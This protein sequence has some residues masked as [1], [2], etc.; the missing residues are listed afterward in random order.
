MKRLFAVIALVLLPAYLHAVDTKSEVDRLFRQASSGEIRFQKLVQ[1]SKDSL[2]A[3]GDSA[4]KYLAAK[5]DVTDAREKL[6]LVDIFRGI[7]KKSTPYLVAA[8][9]TDN[10]DQLR[11]TSRCLAD[12]KD[13]A[14]IVSLMSITTH[15]DFT[16]RGEA[17]TAIG[18]SGGGENTASL[19]APM[20]SDSVDL[21]RKCVVYGL[22]AVK[23]TASLPLLIGALD[24]ESFAVRL[25]AYDAIASLDSLAHPQLI[26]AVGA[27]APERQKTL[28]IRLCGQLKIKAAKSTIQKALEDSTATNRGWA[29]WAF[30]RLDERGAKG[31]LESMAKTETAPFVL[32]QIRDALALLSTS[33]NY[34]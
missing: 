3:M 5:L 33:K 6:T 8:L 1:P 28:L 15:P 19:L 10:K 22:G 18:K 20:L 16:V 11:T 12:I 13:T 29:V 32:S 34:E 23:S 26:A 24:D 4:A 31:K 2:S 7:G 9:K 17:I 30:A 27:S 14:A 25:C 21:V